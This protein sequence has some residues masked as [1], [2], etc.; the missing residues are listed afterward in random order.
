MK[1]DDAINASVC[2]VNLFFFKIGCDTAKTLGK[3]GLAAGAAAAGK[4]AYDYYKSPSDNKR[5]AKQ[6]EK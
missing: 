4:K 3:A 2:S 1:V 6:I 5:E